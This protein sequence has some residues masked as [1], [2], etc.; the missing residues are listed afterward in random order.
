MSWRCAM[1]LLLALTFSSCGDSDDS[2]ST[3][4][5]CGTPAA[6]SRCLEP[7]QA[8]E[9]YVEQSLKYF[10]TLATFVNPLS[11]PNYST[12]VARWEWPPWLLL[13]GFGKTNMIVTDLML[14]LWP[15][16]YVERD[17]RAFPVQP[18]GRCHVIFNYFPDNHCA[19]Y[20]EFTFNDQGE[21]T[22]IEAWSDLPGYLPMAD[23]S[24][25]WAQGDDVH[26]LSTELPGLGNSEGLIDLDAP[27]MEA[28]AQENSDVA[29]FLRRAR[30]PFEAWITEL[31]EHEG[32]YPCLPQ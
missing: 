11:V 23:A 2:E 24:D 32:G 17:C 8:P 29:D 26:R 12:L 6:K 14:K 31:L 13:T 21:M 22:F 5:L 20:E 28:A 16:G 27:W 19:I 9:Y 1:A 10:D 18:F 4:L 30:K 15:T 7:Q 25:V 3:A